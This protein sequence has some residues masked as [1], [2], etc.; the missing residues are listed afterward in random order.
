MLRAHQ[1]AHRHVS[2][3]LEITPVKLAIHSEPGPCS[4][5]RRVGRISVGVRASEV[6]ERTGKCLGNGC[7]LHATVDTYL[8]WT[9]GAKQMASLSINGIVPKIH[10]ASPTVV[11]CGTRAHQIWEPRKIGYAA[12][13]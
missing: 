4:R 6:R 1:S 9:A 3:E 11:R 5:K 2:N 10:S 8:E 7:V 13:E 12:T